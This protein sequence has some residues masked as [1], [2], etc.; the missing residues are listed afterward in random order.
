MHMGPDA[1]KKLLSEA[2]SW[3]CEASGNFQQGPG[4]CP[5]LLHKNAAWLKLANLTE[6]P[7]KRKGSSDATLKPEARAMRNKDAV[8]KP[9]ADISAKAARP[10]QS[11]PPKSLGARDMTAFERFVDVRLYTYRFRGELFHVSSPGSHIQDHLRISC[12]ICMSYCLN[13]ENPFV[14][15]LSP[16]NAISSH[17]RACRL[18]ISKLV[19]SIS[20]QHCMADFT[21]FKISQDL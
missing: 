4:G 6:G 2:E 19:G 9:A 14:P 8:A 13:A 3:K 18:Y 11:A 5:A 17:T 16:P 21:M 15:T 1:E 20:S 7:C 10:T 12:C